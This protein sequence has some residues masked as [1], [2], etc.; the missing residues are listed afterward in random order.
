MNISF[1]LQYLILILISIIISIFA[2]YFY[3]SLQDKKNNIYLS[4]YIIA[5]INL[6]FIIICTITFIFDKHLKYLLLMIYISSSITMLLIYYIIYLNKEMQNYYYDA[7][8]I[9]I[10]IIPIYTILWYNIISTGSYYIKYKEL[11]THTSTM[12]YIPKNMDD[13]KK[14]LI[15]QNDILDFND[16]KLKNL[17]PIANKLYNLFKRYRG[18]ETDS[19]EL[20]QKLLFLNN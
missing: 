3:S 16:F 13:N 14:I 7:F 4:L 1:I 10:A 17:E 9:I 20:I 6:C 5:I 19:K 11:I 15:L 18:H 12:T 8:F 2:I